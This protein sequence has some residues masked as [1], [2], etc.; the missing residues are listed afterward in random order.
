MPKIAIIS[1]ERVWA[2]G[3]GRYLKNLMT[4]LGDDCVG[5][6]LHGSKK[7]R[8]DG[9]I[10]NIHPSMLA[11][12]IKDADQLWLPAIQN[13]FWEEVGELIISHPAPKMA[14][15]NMEIAANSY[16][17]CNKMYESDIKFDLM[18]VHRQAM[19]RIFSDKFKSCRDVPTVQAP[20]CLSP[21]EE[22]IY[23]TVKWEDKERL[24]VSPSRWSS[25][26]RSNQAFMSMSAAQKLGAKVEMWG[27]KSKGLEMSQFHMIES[28]P[29]IK[30]VW[31]EFVANGGVRGPYGAEERTAFL[32]RAVMSIDF[33]VIPGSISATNKFYTESAHPQFVTLE[34][35]AHRSIPIMADDTIGQQL[36]QGYYIISVP[37]NKA[38]DFE[39]APQEIGK[40]IA[41]KLSSMTKEEWEEKTA[42]NW[43]VLQEHNS[44]NSFS[45]TIK[46]CQ[47]RLAA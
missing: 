19:G 42:H 4:V 44:W 1:D 35:V 26:K 31:E 29:K 41:D 37:S 11:E 32:R 30:A 39:K 28:N 43:Q 36:A 38:K 23:E 47:R 27:V 34:S 22:G 20:I 13:K 46:E 3:T 15:H 10:L 8:K 40:W 2:C 9:E 7:V 33:M 17:K 16:M 21:D 5:L 12:H 18:L 6:R 25:C 14:I 24:V 45:N